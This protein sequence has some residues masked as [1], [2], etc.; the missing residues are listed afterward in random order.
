MADAGQRIPLQASLS[1]SSLPQ[2]ESI[3]RPLKRRYTSS[4]LDL[5]VPATVTAPPVMPAFHARPAYSVTAPTPSA[6]QSVHTRATAR[7]PGLAPQ[8][9]TMDPAPGD[10]DAVF[11]HPPFTDFPDAHRYKEGLTYTVLATHPDWFLD[12]SDYQQLNDVNPGGM[13]YPSQLEPPRGWCP[14]K[15]R[16]AKDGWAEGEEPR[17]RCTFCRRTYAGVNAKS[18]WRRHV[19]EKHKIAMA[20]RRENQE[21]KG[22]NSNSQYS[23]ACMP[24]PPLNL[25]T[26][27]NKEGSRSGTATA[28]GAAKVETQSVSISSSR[29]TYRLRPAAE[30][31][32]E[33]QSASA[34]ASF[35][36]VEPDT[37]DGDESG[38]ESQPLS[39]APSLSFMDEGSR[40]SLRA[41]TPPLTPAL[42]PSPTPSCS[43]EFPKPIAESP[44]NPLLTPSFRH[45]PPR[46]PSE[47]PWRLNS[48]ALCMLAQ[49]E[50]SPTVRGL[51]VSPLLLVPRG[52]RTKQSIFS[53][54]LSPLAQSTP[55][56]RKDI[57]KPTPRRLFSESTLP[58]PFTERLKFQGHRNSPLAVGFTPVKRKMIPSLMPSGG[59]WCASSPAKSPGKG[60]GKG[61]GLMGPIHLDDPFTEGTST[62]W[63]AADSDNEKSNSPPDSSPEAESPVLRASQ[64]SQ[65]DASSADVS[66]P[67]SS[68]DSVASG[69]GLLEG[70]S[71]KDRAAAA[72][73]SD[74][75][76]P[77]FPVLARDEPGP[78]C[79]VRRVILGDGSPVPVA[80]AGKTRR[81]LFS[82]PDDVDGD[83]CGMFLPKKRRR[84]TSG[85]R[86]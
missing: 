62:L 52:E 74:E 48:N 12:P 34:P 5:A 76:E 71:L 49:A 25:H 4:T 67:S 81:R 63:T 40:A 58:T 20:N 45:S 64:L 22:R 82:R 8:L 26:E 60:I 68:Q 72:E 77:M 51:D 47:Q 36:A 55:D 33:W 42:S 83:A 15:K 54:P 78:S 17:L 10:P 32:A 39:A 2:P 30:V 27:E 3:P 86:E 73:D 50:S 43:F 35:A 16:E 38:L 56:K 24:N 65:A 80:V 37:D 28:R 46:L 29:S 70:F 7:N 79:G 85:L 19:F 61:L 59:A 21:R 11:I 84:T 66:M 18:M 9:P 57:T 14:A 6:R 41:T 23:V 44:Y 13:K 1:F 31:S 69:L 75:D 53:S